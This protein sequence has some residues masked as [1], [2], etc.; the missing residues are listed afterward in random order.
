MAVTMTSVE[1]WEALRERVQ[2]AA[3][4][5]LVVL[6]RPREGRLGWATELRQLP[7]EI[8]DAPPEAVIVLTPRHD[9]P[10][11]VNRFIRLR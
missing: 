10:G 4:S 5:D 8:L 9:D 11:P 6:L 3:L 2:S 7:E 1:T